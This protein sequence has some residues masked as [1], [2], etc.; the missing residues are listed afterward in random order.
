MSTATAA[1]RARIS[2][3]ALVATPKQQA[4]LMAREDEVLYGGAAGGGKSDALLMFCWLRRMSIPGSRGLILRRNFPELE[5]SLILRSQELWT[6]TGARWQDQR[7]RWVFPNGSIQEFGY[8]ERDEDVFRYH[9]AQYE[10]ICWDEL[11]EFSEYQYRYLLSRLRTTK[12]GVRCLVRAASNPGNVGHAWVKARFVDVAP[13]GTTYVDPETGL[14]RRFIPATLD[15]NPYIDRAA[16]ERRLEALPEAERRALRYGDWDVFAGQYFR[17]WRRHIHVIDPFPIPAYWRRFRS[18]DYGLDMTACYWWAV[19]DQG[20][21]YVYRELYQPDLILSEA[22]RRIL[23]LTPPDERILYTVASPDLW[24]RRQDTG[25]SGVDI[26]A[27]AGLTGLVRADDRRVP[28]WMAMSEYLEPFEDE[29]GQTVARLRFFSTC[30]EAIR[31]IPALVRGDRDPNDIADGQED[32]AAD[33]IRYGVMSRPAA[34][35][36]PELQRERRRARARHTSPVVSSIT[37]Y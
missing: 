22:A 7:K 23:E 25:L 26:M 34:S 15:D 16:Y 13:P 3:R 21:C 28:G 2:E 6:G 37:G 30:T 32:H 19:D 8:C 5:R 11:T 29:A 36:R 12:R 9:S 10:D 27:R 14:T 1:T 31:T 4:F 17:N 18:L 33:S 35:V 20:R 24:N